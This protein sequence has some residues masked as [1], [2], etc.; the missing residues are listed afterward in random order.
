MIPSCWQSACSSIADQ[1]ELPSSATATAADQKLLH[2][3]GSAALA[4]THPH[5]SIAASIHAAEQLLQEQKPACTGMDQAGHGIHQ[6]EWQGGLMSVSLK[7]VHVSSHDQLAGA[8][9][10]Q[11]MVPHLLN[12]FLL[13]QSTHQCGS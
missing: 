7:A 4:A 5:M 6:F 13:M 8:A 2:A 3:Q 9:C 11:I 12:S 10:T 1:C